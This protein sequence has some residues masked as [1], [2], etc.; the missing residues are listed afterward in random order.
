MATYYISVFNNTGAAKQY[1]AFMAPPIVNVSTE[2]FSNVWVQWPMVTTGA[3]DQVTY[4]DQTY[5]FWSQLQASP[6]TNTVVS[7]SQ[8]TAVDV[9][10]NT[11]L[12]FTGDPAKGLGFGAPAN[13]G[14]AS[15]GCYDIITKSDF[16]AANNFVFGL[17]R[18][19]TGGSTP[20]PV[21]TFAGSP[22]VTYNIQPVIKFW[23]AE[24]SYVPGTIINYQSASTVACG[25]D[26]TQH[27]GCFTCQVTQNA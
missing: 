5:G 11:S 6:A 2:V 15:Q 22:N 8:S 20:V 26:F 18:V 17:S 19:G 23:I 25:I 3:Q 24:G 21:A 27:P 10:Q 7:C 9:A 4:S 1:F 13:P 12:F 16:T 14:N